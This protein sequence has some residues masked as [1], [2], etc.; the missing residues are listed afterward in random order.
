MSKTQLAQLAG[1]LEI[2]GRSKMTRDEL[3]EAV[4]GARHP[5]PKAV[6]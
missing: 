4:R 3:Q 2:S 6:S 5:R 1:E